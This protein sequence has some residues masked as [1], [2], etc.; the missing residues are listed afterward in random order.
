MSS[1]HQLL[2]SEIANPQVW[3]ALLASTNFAAA[4]TAAYQQR[5]D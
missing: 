1:K 5:R 2:V 3:A 4:G